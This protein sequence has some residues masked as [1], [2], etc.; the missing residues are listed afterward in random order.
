MS[1]WWFFVTKLQTLFRGSITDNEPLK[2]TEET[3]ELY[4]CTMCDTLFADKDSYLMHF[5]MDTCTVP[6]NIFPENPFEIRTEDD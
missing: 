6:H 1:A 5:R 3:I 4:Q 2:E